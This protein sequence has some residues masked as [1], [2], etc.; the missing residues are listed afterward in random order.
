[1][2]QTTAPNTAT[3]EDGGAPASE[4]TTTFELR[5]GAAE[6]ALAQALRPGSASGRTPFDAA[7]EASEKARR[8]SVQAELDTEAVS[9]LVDSGQLRSA[10]ALLSGRLDE[11]C[12]KAGRGAAEAE[13][14][15]AQMTD[16]LER[17]QR[18]AEQAQSLL[19]QA[20]RP[21]SGVDGRWL[22]QAGER[23]AALKGR[24]AQASAQAAEARETAFMA[25]A[26]TVAAR[27]G[28]SLA[29]SDLERAELGD[30]IVQIE[31]VLPASA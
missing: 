31:S 17:A 26:Q 20:E 21:D 19:D 22:A 1:M 27:I 6:D 2:T 24:I 18:A 5:L 29:E 30:Q 7:A 4:L 3:R 11:Q 9:M 8:R 13:A 16:D 28:R 14:I 25:L 23:S 12:Q 15:A 10:R